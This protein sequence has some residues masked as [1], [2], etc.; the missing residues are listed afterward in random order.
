MAVVFFVKAIL[1]LFVRLLKEAQ[2]GSSK[3][4]QF[5]TYFLNHP[6]GGEILMIFHKDN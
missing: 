4:K 2:G 6:R 1:S 5:E 3:R